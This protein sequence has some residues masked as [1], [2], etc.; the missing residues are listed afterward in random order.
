MAKKCYISSPYY[1]IFTLDAMLSDHIM[2]LHRGCQTSTQMIPSTSSLSSLSTFEQSVLINRLKLN[3]GE[4]IDIL[5]HDIMKKYI[6]Y[7]RRYVKPQLNAEACKEIQ[8]YFLDLRQSN[9]GLDSTPITTRYGFVNLFK[10]SISTIFCY[11]HFKHK[12]DLK[13]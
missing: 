9:H 11:N 2:N 6:A 10:M 7:A 8:K 4:N 1:F 3:P 12:F 13:S 5:P